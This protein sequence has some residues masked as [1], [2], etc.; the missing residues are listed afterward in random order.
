MRK[1]YWLKWLGLRSLVSAKAFKSRKI[2]AEEHKEMGLQQ[3]VLIG[4]KSSGRA[5]YT[6]S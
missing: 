4:S 2:P 6:I 5:A 3:E 1:R